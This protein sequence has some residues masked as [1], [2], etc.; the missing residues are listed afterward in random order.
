MNLERTPEQQELYDAT[1]EFARERLNADVAALDQADRF[2]R[3]A[4]K[5]AAE[6]GLLGLPMP[7][8]HGGQ[9]RDLL[10]TLIAMEALGRG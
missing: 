4:W 6:F 8:E 1:L 3:D 7:V 5:R 2:D 10:T 9:G